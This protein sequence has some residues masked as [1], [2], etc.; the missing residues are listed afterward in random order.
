MVNSQGDFSMNYSLNIEPTD[1]NRENVVAYNWKLTIEVKD[2]INNYSLKSFNQSKRSTAIS[3]GEA[4]SRIMRT[5]QTELNNKFY[6]DF[7]SYL[8]SM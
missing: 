1:I 4:K 8:N 5:V 7:Q 3:E 2:N 6:K